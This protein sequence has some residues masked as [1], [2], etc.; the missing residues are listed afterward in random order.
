MQCRSGCS[1]CCR[2]RLSITRVE[3]AFL[4]RGLARIPGSIRK[5]ISLA[6]Q[7]KTRE[8]CPALDPQGRCR[9][10][11]SRPLICRSYGVPLRHR[12]DVCI[13]NPPIIDVCDK[14][15]VGQP[16]TGLPAADVFDQTSLDTAVSEID[17]EY[18]K[19]NGLPTGERV[20]LAQIL[21]GLD[22]PAAG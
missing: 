7:E 1:D 8:M 9:V 4:R 16:L 17:A 13:V 12:R 19:R 5:E 18:C 14:N 20:P 10:Y 11:A 22:T 6:A 21:A 3:E 2:A 15:F